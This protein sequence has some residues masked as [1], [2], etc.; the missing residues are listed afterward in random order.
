MEKF[1]QF[2]QDAEK[3][4]RTLD[5]LIYVTFPVV[6]DKRLLLKIIIE[7]K[8]AITDCIN[9]ILQ[10][11]YLF[12]RIKLYNQPQTNLKTFIEKS[13]KRYN[14]TNREIKLIL[15]LFKLT[16]A[17]K[18]SP[19]EFVREGK[20]VI[21]SEKFQPHTITIEKTKEFLAIAKSILSKTKKT[22]KN[23]IR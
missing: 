21:M 5:H 14:I 19:M 2:L 10:Y 1:L 8:T 3:N 13:S 11:E 23:N 18:K 16:E 9:A 7:T 22:F 12:K 4:I 17:H 15:E 6:K 20:I